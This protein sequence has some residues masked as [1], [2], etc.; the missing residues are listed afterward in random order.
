MAKHQRQVKASQKGDLANLE[1]NE[2]FDDS[3]LPD[4]A[5][6]ERLHVLDNNILAWLKEKSGKEQ[7]FRH[8]AHMERLSL[9][10]KQNSKDH[11][12]LRFSIIVY[13]LLVAG[14]GYASF[15]LIGAGKNIGGSI[16]G[17]TTAI[18]ALA[19]LFTRKPP[20]NKA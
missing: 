6:I 20:Q 7:D 9:I 15:M 17:G 14:M 8:K 12:T 19:V 13:F 10:K 18:L 2:L 1:H 4:V 16:F 3:M 5:Q 11:F